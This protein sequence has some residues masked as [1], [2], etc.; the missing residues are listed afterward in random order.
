MDLDRGETTAEISSLAD[1]ILANALMFCDQE[2]EKR[3]GRRQYRDEQGGIRGLE[4]R[5]G[6]SSFSL[7][8]APGPESSPDANG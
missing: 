1:V 8:R 5:K 6:D 7:P 3:Y 2:L 4:W